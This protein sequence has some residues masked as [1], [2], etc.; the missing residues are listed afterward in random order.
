MRRHTHITSAYAR[1]IRG[2]EIQAQIEALI[3]RDDLI[4]MV[5]KL[6]TPAVKPQCYPLIIGEHR[7]GKP[8]LIL[9][10]TKKLNQPKG[11]LYVHVKTDKD[12]PGDLAKAMQKTLGLK[13]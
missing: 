8:S 6:I 13:I 2:P 9:L 4:K 10:A 11:V 1:L 7:T 3:P 12:K 5:E